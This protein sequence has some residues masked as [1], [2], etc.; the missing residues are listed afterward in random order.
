MSM[1]QR[2][3][4]LVGLPVALALASLIPAEEG[5]VLKTYRDPVGIITSCMG[6]TGPELKMGQT[7]T[8]EQCNE[9]MYADLIK[10]AEPA[11]KC[12]G[13][14]Q[15]PQLVAA[16]DFAFNKGVNGFCTSTYARKLK[17]RDPAACNEPLR[18]T[19]VTVGGRLVSCY[20]PKNQCRGLVTRAERNSR[21]C[22]GDMS[23]LAINVDFTQG[24]ELPAGETP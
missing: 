22:Q 7:F 14:P 2:F 21:M 8:R 12:A 11:M 9:Q 3:I 4:A 16:I 15:G 17:A 5:V 13:N 20:D 24:G 18:W 23:D 19:N 6:H 1:K 10:H